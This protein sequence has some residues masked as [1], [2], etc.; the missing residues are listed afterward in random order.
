MWDVRSLLYPASNRWPEC[1]CKNQTVGRIQFLNLIFT[2]NADH[3]WKP[4]LTPLLPTPKPKVSFIIATLFYFT[5][6][7]WV[8]K[9]HISHHNQ[10]SKDIHQSIKNSDFLLEISKCHSLP[11]GHIITNTS[12]KIH[13]QVTVSGF[14][15]MYPQNSWKH[16]LTLYPKLTI[17]MSLPLH[18]PT[19]TLTS[20]F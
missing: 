12:H 15:I 8:N 14:L 17:S 18:R 1:S 5:N 2:I 7:R 19:V 16:T 3:N 11:H 20:A 4:D 6:Q 9:Q 10:P 13:W